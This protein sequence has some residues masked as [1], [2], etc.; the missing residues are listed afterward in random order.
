MT[1]ARLQAKQEYY[2]GQI[3]ELQKEGVA[4]PAYLAGYASA[5][6]DSL[7]MLGCPLNGRLKVLA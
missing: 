3:G 7:E 1:C 5:A 4:V 6:A 2:L